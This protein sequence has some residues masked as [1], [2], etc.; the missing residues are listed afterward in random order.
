MSIDKSTEVQYAYLVNIIQRYTTAYTDLSKDIKSFCEEA[1]VLTRNV[2]KSN[3]DRE[4]FCRNTKKLKQSKIKDQ[5]L[6]EGRHKVGF[7]IPN[8]TMVVSCFKRR[9]EYDEQKNAREFAELLHRTNELAPNHTPQL[10]AFSEG[11]KE[12]IAPFVIVEK[13]IGEN[14]DKISNETINWIKENLATFNKQVTD[15]FSALDSLAQVSIVADIQKLDNIFYDKD[16]GFTVV[17]LDIEDSDFFDGW[18]L[19]QE[20]QGFIRKFQEIGI[21]AEHPFFKK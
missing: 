14:L 18:T 5:Y 9:E 20:A 17:D 21:N 10:I 2:K 13:A 12:K 15:F 8:T 7:S 1:G 6:N 19:Q 11:K 16:K 3:D 4:R